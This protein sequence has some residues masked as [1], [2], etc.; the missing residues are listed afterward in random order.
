[1]QDNWRGLVDAPVIA[2][3][4][5]LVYIAMLIFIVGIG[6]YIIPYVIFLI[7]FLIII[8]NLSHL[9]FFKKLEQ[10]P[11]Y[12]KLVFIF[13]IAL[14]LRLVLLFQEQVI[15]RDVEM[16]V[17]RAQEMIGGSIPYQEFS[18]NKP[19]LYAYMLQFLGI[20]L[21]P[22]VI[23]F[24]A[25]FSFVDAFV[26]VIIFYLCMYKFNENFSFKA[27][28]IYALCPLP[29]V[30]IGL[31]GH[32]EPVVMVFVLLSLFLLFKR[33]YNI[34]AFFLGIGFA[35]KFFPIV[36]LPFFA[37]KVQSWKS[38]FIYFIIFSIPFIISIVPMLYLSPT[39]FTD[40]LFVQGYS[41]TAKKSFAFIFRSITG[42]NS[43][44]G[45]KVSLIIT[46]IFMLAILAMFI[47][48]VRKRFDA[49]LWFKIIVGTFAI[50]YGLFFI[51]SIKFFKT[52]LGLNDPLAPMAILTIIYF[53]IIFLVMAKFKKYLEV[54]ISKKEQIFI[55]S[56]FSLIFLLF[57]S[58]Q[59][60][61]WY[62]LW[63]L[64]FVLC[65]KVNR[66]RYVLLW[67]IFWNFE[68]IGLSLLPGFVLG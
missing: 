4:A 13:L 20:T 9:K 64:P 16:Y 47:S 19:P 65:I 58:S 1:M 43:I 23:Q 3:A 37:W 7:A 41:W 39:G 56:A 62:L 66:I 6:Y 10:K 57:S 51:A 35:L 25:F 52:E 12:I 68:G 30:G 29:I 34:S 36:L 63:I 42:S 60:N 67:I 18:V 28:M 53:P 31:S 54:K 40:Y 11:L 5:F 55:I 32:Y 44:F 49:T 2:K 48:W 33:H 45:I 17:Y 59:Y 8:P 46:A 15:T 27:G 50:Y 22:G 38:R 24:R 14:F 61:P 21:G 26:A